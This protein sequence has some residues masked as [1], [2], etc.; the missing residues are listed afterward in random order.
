MPIYEFRCFKCDATFE[1][2]RKI[3]DRTKPCRCKKCRSTKTEQLISLCDFSLRGD[4]ANTG[5]GTRT[6]NSRKKNKP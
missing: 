1:V 4:W 2:E 3:K 5:Y 6:S